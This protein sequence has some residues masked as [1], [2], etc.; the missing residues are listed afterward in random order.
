MRSGAL[1]MATEPQTER[2]AHPR[3][4]AA[5]LPTGHHFGD[6]VERIPVRVFRHSSEASRSVAHEIAALVRERAAAGR[7]CVL[8]LATGSTPVDV[9]DELVRMHREDGLSLANVVTF[10]LDE[11]Y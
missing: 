3:D 2:T 11:Y 1:V 5:L 7:T 4:E 9:Y 8:G 6:A 10:N